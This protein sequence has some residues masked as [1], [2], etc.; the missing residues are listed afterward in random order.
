M[1]LKELIE[2][3]KKLTE[4]LTELQKAK[5]EKDAEIEALTAKIEQLRNCIKM[6]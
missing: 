4:Q 3:V 6:S 2:I 1:L 5:A